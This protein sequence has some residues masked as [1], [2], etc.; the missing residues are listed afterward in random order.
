MEGGSFKKGRKKVSWGNEHEGQLVIAGISLAWWKLR[1]TWIL[2]MMMRGRMIVQINLEIQSVI[3]FWTEPLT[4]SSS[5]P[6]QP[7]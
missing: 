6:C 1:I 3:L 2:G 7:S 4:N 5:S